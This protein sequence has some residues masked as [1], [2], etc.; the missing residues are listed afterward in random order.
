[1]KKKIGLLLAMLA[2]VFASFG[3]ATWPNVQNLGTKSTTVDAKNALLVDSV[4]KLPIVAPDPSKRDTGIIYYLRGDSSLYLWVGTKFIKFKDVNLLYKTIDSMKIV[5]DARYAP[6]GVGAFDSLAS[7]GGNFHTDGFNV[8]KYVQRK[9]SAAN[10]TFGYVTQ[11]SRQK[12]ADSLLAVLLHRY[13]TSAGPNWSYVTWSSRQKLADSILGVV[14]HKYDTAAGSNFTY[15]TWASRQKLADSI[16]ALLNLRVA[17]IGGASFIGGGT[18]AS[19][20]S[21]PTGTGFWYA[22]DQKI[23]YYWNGSTWS[24]ATDAQGSDVANLGN[25][26]GMQAGTWVARPAS[27]SARQYYWSTDSAFLSY[28]DG[29]IWKDLKPGTSTGGSF[30]LTS[31]GPVRVVGTGSVDTILSPEEVGFKYNNSSFPNLTDFAQNTGSASASSGHIVT[32]VGASISDTTKYLALPDVGYDQRWVRSY[33]LLA[34]TKTST[35]ICPSI[36]PKSISQTFPAS[37]EGG[38]DGS[39]GAHAGQTFIRGQGMGTPVY[40]TNTLVWN[41]TDSILVLT[42]RDLDTFYV[43]AINIMAARPGMVEVKYVVSIGLTGGMSLENAGQTALWFKGDAVTIVSLSVLS[44]DPVGSNMG[45]LAD[46]KGQGYNALYY[47][48]APGDRI[49]NEYGSYSNYGMT[50]A[51][52]EDLIACEK[53]IAARK[54]RTVLLKIGCNNVTPDVTFQTNW[55]NFLAWLDLQGIY[56]VV[57]GP[58]FETARDQTA[59]HV[60]QQAHSSGR[61]INVFDAGKNGN[62]GNRFVNTSDGIHP[63]PLYDDSVFFLERRS[64]LLKGYTNPMRPNGLGKGVNYGDMLFSSSPPGGFSGAPLTWLGDSLRL[65]NNYAFALNRLVLDGTFFPALYFGDQTLGPLQYVLVSQSGVFK[66]LKFSGSFDVFDFNNAGQ[67]SYPQAGSSLCLGCGIQTAAGLVVHSTT[68]TRVGIVTQGQIDVGNS[69]FGGAGAGADAAVYLRNQNTGAK[70]NSVSANNNGLLFA[71]ANAAMVLS[72]TLPNV[73]LNGILSPTAHFHIDASSATDPS[74]KIDGGVLLTTPQN[75][76]WEVTTGGSGHAYWTDGAGV[77]HQLDQ[78]AAPP[79]DANIAL[80]MDHTDNTKQFKFDLT[81]IATGN[82]RTWTVPNYSATFA[83]SDHAVSYTSTHD[84]TGATVT[85]AT[86]TALT[87]NNTAASTSYTD[88]AVALAPNISNTNLTLNA[89][90]TLTVP[91]SNTLTITGGTTSSTVTI[92][93]ATII[94]TPSAATLGFRITE[95]SGL[96]MQ[97]V[98]VQRSLTTGG[99]YT[100]TISQNTTIIDPAST[101]ATF[102]INLPAAANTATG[103]EYTIFFG[104][105]VTTGAVITAVTFGTGATAVVGIVPTT[106]NAGDRI[107]FMLEPDGVGGFRWYIKAH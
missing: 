57:E 27:P 101:L 35:S 81:Q 98:D 94:L 56:W 91:N 64:G 62:T 3:Q 25:S 54:F 86:Q 68:G 30:T 18:L 47:G 103:L 84:F 33:I 31:K 34:P 71:A 40:S 15:V 19:R 85:V 28:W 60:Y 92:S 104:G 70:E 96:V 102:T 29:S 53:D 58:M 80:S 51:K 46:S 83:P 21:S 63:T 6:I 14:L 23:M 39:T 11:Q 77:R 2:I 105:Q 76:A 93:P 24:Q 26:P 9:D 10:E 50:G 41:S 8:S 65:K 66:F 13:D 32:G 72:R 44:H 17:N 55:N 22:S 107:S 73:G 1:M 95:I 36:G 37:V 99:S 88:A 4:L 20:P 82:T 48:L 49:G 74:F 45:I 7:Q 42:E 75:Y 97:G 5:N 43:R 61:Y 52:I 69:D 100:L 106:V 67:S 89:N 90:R 59:M 87:N 16:N 79:F 12:L 38:F 78:Q